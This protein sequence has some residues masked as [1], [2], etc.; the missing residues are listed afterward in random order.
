[1]ELKKR[2]GAGA[3]LIE[4]AASGTSLIQELKSGNDVRPIGIKPEKDKVTRMSAGSVKI[5][6]GQVFLPE[7]APWLD[8]FVAEVL[9]FPQGKHDDQVDSV[10]QFLGWVERP[11]GIRMVRVII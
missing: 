1:M 2:H 10:S 4:D 9:A 8:G 3:V 11:A 6:A 7:K 5:E